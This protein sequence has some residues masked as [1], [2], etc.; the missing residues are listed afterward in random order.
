MID[1][2]QAPQVDAAPVDVANVPALSARPFDAAPSTDILDTPLA[3]ESSADDIIMRAQASAGGHHPHYG[4]LVKKMLQASRPHVTEA[5]LV[6]R[7]RTGQVIN[8]GIHFDPAPT[9][10]AGI[11]RR[12]EQ[13]QIIIKAKDGKVRPFEGP[14]GFWGTYGAYAGNAAGDLSTSGLNKPPNSPDSTV[15][16]GEHAFLLMRERV[17]RLRDKKIVAEAVKRH[18]LK[19]I[20]EK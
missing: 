17:Q 13:L 7:G 16:H 5:E 8:Y 14:P 15:R 4:P 11:Y 20:R 19:E 2:N 1:H 18:G 10:A 3:A 12:V 6:R 9:A